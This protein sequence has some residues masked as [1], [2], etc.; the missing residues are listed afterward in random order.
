MRIDA[1]SLAPDPTNAFKLPERPHRLN[2]SIP[3]APDSHVLHSLKLIESQYDVLSINPFHT[4]V[5]NI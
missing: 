3:N 2:I 5:W 4:Q 1:H